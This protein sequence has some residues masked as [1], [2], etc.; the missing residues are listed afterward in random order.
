[1]R[2]SAPSAA[3]ETKRDLSVSPVYTTRTPFWTG[4]TTCSGSTS[5]TRSPLFRR[6]MSGP[7]FTP[8]EMALSRSSLPGM[9]G[10]DTENPT[11]GTPCSVAKASTLIERTMNESPGTTSVDSTG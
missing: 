1:M 4:P 7:S 2:T 11:E 3:S 8:S 9:S 6:A 5:P 10:S